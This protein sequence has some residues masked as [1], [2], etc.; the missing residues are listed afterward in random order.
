MFSPS[1]TNLAKKDAAVDALSRVCSVMSSS[2]DLRALHHELYHP[3]IT[4]MP[5]VVR[6]RNL[7][8][9]VEANIITSYRSFAE[10]KLRFYKTTHGVLIKATQP[11]EKLN[12]DFKIPRIENQK[13]IPACYIVRISLP[14]YI[15]KLGNNIFAL[16]VHLVWSPS[17]YPF[18]PRKLCFQRRLFF[19]NCMRNVSGKETFKSI[20]CN[21]NIY[22]GACTF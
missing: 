7:P 1:I 15:S 17:I 10:Y 14:K 19:L 18:R 6:S 2:N 9:F 8:Y 11:F 3:G 13:Q 5:H 21:T 4:R 12:V 20:H 16:L 22:T